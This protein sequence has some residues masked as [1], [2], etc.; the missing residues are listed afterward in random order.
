MNDSA[1]GLVTE[2][3]SVDGLVIA[4]GDSRDHS[5]E[6]VDFGFCNDGD[7]GAVGI[8]KR[9]N[10][11]A[12]GIRYEISRTLPL[13]FLIRWLDVQRSESFYGKICK[14]HHETAY[15]AHYGRSSACKW[16]PWAVL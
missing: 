5:D 2:F 1:V 6:F 14:A 11:L 9:W 8:N 4:F 16:I 7:D 3:V 12:C 10:S 15:R 13:S